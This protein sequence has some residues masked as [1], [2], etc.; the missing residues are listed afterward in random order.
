M[1]V[2]V[3]PFLMRICRK[4]PYFKLRICNSTPR[5]L[6]NDCI[7]LCISMLKNIGIVF[8]DSFQSSTI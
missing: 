5:L 3:D 2:R 8:D 1:I 7:P 6:K 4:S